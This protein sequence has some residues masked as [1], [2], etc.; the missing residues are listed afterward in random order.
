MKTI[1]KIKFFVFFFA[2]NLISYTSQSQTPTGFCTV[3]H[4]PCNNDGILVTK[5]TSGMTLP[6]TF[7]Y[8]Y[9]YSGLTHDSIFSFTDSLVNFNDAYNSVRI[10]DSSGITLILNTG[11]VAPFTRDPLIINNAICPDTLGTIEVTINGGIIP[12][13]VDWWI[14]YYG[15]LGSIYF[16]TGNPMSLPVGA[17]DFKITDSN[18]CAIRYNSE[19]GTSGVYF[20]SQDAPFTYLFTSTDASCTNGS[21]TISNISGGISPYTYDW[22]NGSSTSTVS[23]FSMGQYTVTISDSQGCS[24]VEYFQIDQ[25]VNINVNSTVTNATCL[26]NNGSITTFG[27]GGTPPYT[28][29]YNNGA[30]SQTVSGLAGGTS[31]SVIVIDA[32][33]CRS[34]TYATSINYYTPISVTYTTNPSACSDTTGG[35][36]LTITGGVSPYNIDWNVYPTQNGLSLINVSE[37]QYTFKVTD[38]NGC[39]RTGIVNIPSS[40][41]IFAQIYSTPSVCPNSNGSA[42]LNI[43]NNTPLSF[44]W[45]TGDTTQNIINIPSGNY[46]CTI[47]DTSGCSIIKNTIVALSSQIVLGLNTTLASCIY[48]NDGNILTNVS[49]GIP[50]YT[51]HWSNGQL[52]A[53]CTNLYTGH[54][55]VQVQDSLGCLKSGYTLLGYNTGNDSCYCTLSGNVFVDQN[56]DCILSSNESGV[57]NI[58]IHCTGFGYTYTDSSGAY[59]FKVPSGSYILSESIQNTYPLASCQNNSIS[60]SVNAQSGCIITNDFANVINPLHDIQ[61]YRTGLTYPVP[62]NQYIQK[63]I[64]KNEGTIDESNIQLG[65]NHDGQL[66][67]NYFSPVLYTQVSPVLN[68]DWYSV[69]SSFPVLSPGVQNIILTNFNVPTNIPLLTELNF[70]DTTAFSP[71]MSNWLVDYTPWNNICNYRPVVIG[72][73]DPNFKEVNPKGTSDDGIISYADSILTYTIHFQNT[74]SY[75]AQNIVIIDTLD[76]ALDLT[77]LHPVYSEHNFSTS[78]SENGILKFTFS[79]IQLPWQG[80]NEIASRGLVIYTV[81]LKNNL[82]IGTKIRNT[83]NIYFDYNAPVTTN[84]TLNTI[85]SNTSIN[86][87]NIDSKIKLFPNPVTFD[88]YV[89]L[90]NLEEVQNFNI[91][92]V[93]G[94]LILSGYLSK[95]NNKIS[96]KN[97]SGGLY[98]LNIKLKN[99]KN[100]VDKFIKQ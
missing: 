69:I 78:I 60:V 30:T 43:Y 61:V 86:T 76:I 48:T 34:G 97:L 6:L 57:E 12:A 27:S 74:G 99:G 63:T 72:S 73:F 28:Y 47:T 21:G 18:G 51:Y 4:Q 66:Q 24:S 7:I 36:T 25:T 45:S 83:A 71:P 38:V 1:L 31:I 19:W 9:G 2:F 70:F 54:Y 11:L 37:G 93:T 90:D 94:R 42:S 91:F 95:I 15:Y 33:G 40:T 22:S 3:I 32:N 23:D 52:G 39:V 41:Q 50:P 8:G 88:L 79:N 96:T 62:G 14:Y 58:M 44:L 56:N 75:Y 46:S 65:F 53:S 13:S 29:L 55:S 59:S 77:T 35:A 98:F 20:M 10:T 89:V 80:Q 84:T 67:I 68:P 85:V 82:P 26:N 17:Y 49:G 100:I 5:I 92:D 16:G 64:I 81:K 87:P